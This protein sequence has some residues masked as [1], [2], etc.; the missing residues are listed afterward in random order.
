MIEQVLDKVRSEGIQMEF[1]DLD[2]D[3]FAHVDKLILKVE[4]KEFE[5]RP[6]TKHKLEVV[7]KNK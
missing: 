5:I 7:M 2:G 6:L 1:D 3:Y 4:G